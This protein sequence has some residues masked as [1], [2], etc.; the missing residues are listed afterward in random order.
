M[1]NIRGEPSFARVGYPERI[2]RT[3]PTDQVALVEQEQRVM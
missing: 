2:I 1:R 3:V